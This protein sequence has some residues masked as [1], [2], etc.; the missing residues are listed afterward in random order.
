MGNFSI[1]PG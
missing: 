1:A